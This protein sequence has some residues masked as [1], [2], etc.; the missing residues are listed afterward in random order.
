MQLRLDLGSAY[1][2][3]GQ[4]EGEVC[5]FV[6][7]V[8]TG[9]VKIGTTRDLRQRLYDFRRGV[10]AAQVY[11]VLR[12]VPGGRHVESAL[13]RR[14]ARQRVRGEVFRL[15]P[16]RADIELLTGN[17]PTVPVCCDCGAALNRARAARCRSCEGR[18]R[19]DVAET[20][21][22]A[23]AFC[24]T[25]G[26]AVSTR[27]IANR[28]NEPPMCRPCGMRKA[29]T[30][31]KYV[32]AIMAARTAAG[33]SRR[34]RC[35]HCQLPLNSGGNRFHAACWREVERARLGVDV[36]AGLNSAGE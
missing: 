7:I 25:C 31:P 30:D 5:Y 16:I 29:W 15:E 11:R 35:T 6:E 10:G 18:R 21:R 27:S 13:H 9:L 20:A 32:R 1:T 22:L 26:A 23:R 28:P 33:L 3:L 8:G 4:E 19:A 34:K 12:V 24:I 14:F 17:E 2:P 36:G